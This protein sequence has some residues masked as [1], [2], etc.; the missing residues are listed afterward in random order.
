MERRSTCSCHSSA[1]LIQYNVWCVFISRLEYSSTF[2]GEI[3][4][5]HL[6]SMIQGLM[7]TKHDRDVSTFTFCSPAKNGAW[8]IARVNGYGDPRATKGS[9]ITYH[10]SY[11]SPLELLK[12][13]R[14]IKR[15]SC[16]STNMIRNA[17]GHPNY[18]HIDWMYHYSGNLFVVDASAGPDVLKLAA[19]PS[20]LDTNIKARQSSTLLSGGAPVG[21]NLTVD[22]EWQFVRL[23]Y[24]QETSSRF[25]GERE[26][27]AVWYDF[28]N[29]YAE[30]ANSDPL[31]EFCRRFIV[32]AHN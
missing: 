18:E 3:I 2:S 13:A 8:K 11:S 6:S 10:S 28:E 29:R 20:Q 22:A 23:I 12:R 15:A 17:K 19:R 25:P 30:Y 31:F 5:G 16:T 4:W 7:A 26:L 27:V 32:S 24:G 21:C 14:P 1:S 9:W